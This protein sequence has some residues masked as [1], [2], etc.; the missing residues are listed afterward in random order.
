MA[1]KMLIDATHPE[2]TRVA[3]VDDQKLSDYDFESTIKK[4]LKGNIYLAK[5]AR[6]EP[7]LQAA[8]I[9]YGGD[10]HGFLAFSEIHPDYFRIPISDRQNAEKVLAE[11][12]ELEQQKKNDPLEEASTED[13]ADSDAVSTFG[14][15]L[16]VEEEMET[17]F[18]Q[19][20]PSLHRLYKIQEVIKKN[21]VILVQVTKEERGGKGAALT[22]YISMAGR[23]C[24]LMP[25]SPNSGGISRK[26]ASSKDR[27]RLREILDTLNTP[28]GMGLIIRT[29]GMERSKVEIKRDA[30]YLM[31]TWNDIRKVTLNSIAPCLIYQEDEIIKRAIRDLYSKDVDQILVE[32]EEGY[33]VAKNFMKTLMPSH[34]KR[35]QL[36]KDEESPLFFKHRIEKQ[37]DE[38]HMP[39][40]RLPSGGSIVIHPT[41]A[42]VSIDINSGRST[43]ER[44]I[45]ETAF[46]TNLEAAD[47]IYRQVRLRDL[48]GLIVIDFIDMDNSKNTAAVEKRVRDVF[49]NDRARVQIGK[50]SAFGLLE[51]S[52]QRLKASLLET[53][54]T[55]CTHCATTGYVRS[56]ESTALMILRVLEEEGYAKKASRTLLKLPTSVAFYLLNQKRTQLAD[57]EKRHAIR[58]DLEGDAS[59]HIPQYQVV[60]LEML[61][62]TLVDTEEN[63]PET[64]RR[65]DGIQRQPT[66]TNHQQ[67]PRT[68]SGQPRSHT[69]ESTTPQAPQPGQKQEGT[70]RRRRRRR[71]NNRQ[72]PLGSQTIIT[73]ESSQDAQFQKKYDQSLQT[74]AEKEAHF[75]LG[76]KSVDPFT[77]DLSQPL[78]ETSDETP[79]GANRNRR[80][81]NRNRNRN[82]NR[83]FQQNHNT[84]SEA[85]DQGLQPSVEAN[86]VPSKPAR[87]TSSNTAV[88]VR[89]ESTRVSQENK[90]NK[91]NTPHQDVTRESS[92]SD[93]G[94]KARKTRSS[95]RTRKTPSDTPRPSPDHLVDTTLKSEV[96]MDEKPLK[97]SGTSKAKKTT[98]STK[99]T[100]LEPKEKKT[101]SKKKVDST[102][103]TDA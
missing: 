6:V 16:D 74:A 72:N 14:G 5:I 44:H 85:S 99:K 2:E 79:T 67:S 19:N 36:Y 93:E 86:Q 103:S 47:E 64:G 33:K 52:R 69:P 76:N 58:F 94:K 3:I 11:S 48:A 43:K 31:R 56:V 62:E 54:F 96:G 12:I 8:F 41:E 4:T 34:S 60:R 17:N 22:T 20:T 71:G 73:S 83:P 78:R 82:R 81:R 28:E 91:T 98:S 42:L 25:N 84:S 80:R 68:Q 13:T 26:I 46:K 18:D 30:E 29:A 9:D 65:Q 1:K 95:S 10:R 40:V 87:E 92:N 23:Y 32:G 45:E 66:P 102:D 21:Q 15:E 51:I 89:D 57:I 97:K 37:I 27:K 55:P 7:S 59:L 100:D 77:Q 24:V 101:R 35:V 75:L 53:A 88:M 50:I 49:R 61:T 38:M 90:E 70:G 63:Q 39:V